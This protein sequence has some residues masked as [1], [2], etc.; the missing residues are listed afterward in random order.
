MEAQPKRLKSSD[1]EII[2]TNL[3]EEVAIEQNLSL[4]G[5]GN[6]TCAPG[7]R[8]ERVSAEALSATTRD[9]RSDKR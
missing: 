2:T 7:V 9:T 8:L 3:K 5:G 6:G 4:G 1:F